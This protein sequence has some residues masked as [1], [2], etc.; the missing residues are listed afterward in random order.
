M[1]IEIA[2]RTTVAEGRWP[3]GTYCE[4]P[5]D[6]ILMSAED[7]LADTV[8]PRADA[9]G[10]DVTR[11]HAFEGVPCVDADGEVVLRPPT[12]GDVAALEEAIVATS[13]RLLIVDVLM[14]C[15]PARTLTKIR[16]SLH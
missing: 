1:A 3:D 11:I 10:A 13:A 6:V 12:L 9:A 7:G 14:A 5:G 4:H 16:T 15:P 2:A 8:R